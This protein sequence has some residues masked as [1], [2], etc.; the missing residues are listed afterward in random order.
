MEGYHEQGASVLTFR[1]ERYDGAGNRLRPVP[2]QLRTRG[3][4][5][6][7]SEGDEVRVTGRWKDGTLRI[8]RV[9]NLTTGASIAGKS[10]KTLLLV[11]LTLVVALVVVLAVIFVRA[12]NAF[13]DDV[14]RRQREFQEQ[15]DQRNRDSQKKSD[16]QHRLFCERA[17][18]NGATPPGC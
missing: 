9:H 13:Q 10:I 16:E 5:G 11:F 4:D 18:Q 3:Y 2:V 17:K 12:G 7:V 15:V 1:V 6:S 14:D 8:R